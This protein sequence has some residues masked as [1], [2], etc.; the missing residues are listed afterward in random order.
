MIPD[1]AI[2]NR[3]RHRPL[4]PPPQLSSATRATPLW[5]VPVMMGRTPLSTQRLNAQMEPVSV[6]TGV[7]ERGL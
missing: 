4:K 1:C 5:I 2:V 3:T 6:D 7:S